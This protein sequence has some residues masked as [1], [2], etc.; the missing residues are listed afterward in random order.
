MGREVATMIA[1]GDPT[2]M[3]FPLTPLP[4]TRFNRLAQWIAT[5]VIIPMERFTTRVE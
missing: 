1:S 5:N 4:R 3:A 2:S